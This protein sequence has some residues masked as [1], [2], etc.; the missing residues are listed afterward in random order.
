MGGIET[1]L[2]QLVPALLEARPG[3]QLSLFLGPRGVEA[4]RD[5]PWLGETTVE[6]H[7]ALG[8]AYT[9]ALTEMTLLGWLASRADLDVLHS[10]ALTA[11]LLTRPANVLTVADVIWLREPESV[12]RAVSL[13]WRTFV[14][15][16][17]RRADRVISHSSSARRE[18][19]EDFR[20]PEERIDVVPHAAG[21]PAADAVPEA[22]VRERFGLGERKVVL[23]VSALRTH[24]NLVRLVRALPGVLRSVDDVVL[25]LPGNP[26]RHQ[27]ELAALAQELGVGEAVRFPGWVSAGELEGL[28]RAAS[29]FVFPSRHEGF[30]LPVLEAMRRGVPVACSNASAL[31]EVAGDAALYFDPDRPDEIAAALVRLLTDRPTAEAYVELGLERQASFTWR[32][33]AEETL[34]SYERALRAKRPA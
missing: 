21:E 3:L 11:P 1:Y 4:L 14:P 18:I 29:C 31:P 19:A 16:V 5:E 27:D 12:G 8:R 9:R 34:R 24:K 26:T 2:R 15:A 25:V 6:I 32:R 23:S 28:Y 17:A 7:P 33:T 20:I 13:F 10:V 30:G 22:E